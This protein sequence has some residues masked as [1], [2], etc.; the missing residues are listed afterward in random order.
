MTPGVSALFWTCCNLFQDSR[1]RF[2]CMPCDVGAQVNGPFRCLCSKSSIAWSA[3][4]LWSPLTEH[5]DKCTQPSRCV[6]SSQAHRISPMWWG[7]YSGISLT[8]LSRELKKK[9]IYQKSYYL[10][11]VSKHRKIC[12]LGGELAFVRQLISHKERQPTIHKE[13][14]GCNAATLFA[15][16]GARIFKLS[17]LIFSIISCS[18]CSFFLYSSSVLDL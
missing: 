2:T 10:K 9:S 3:R 6:T 18:R 11:W 7:L 14:A 5:E 8:Q 12:T 17:F 15:R 13:R 16:C 1:R 4:G